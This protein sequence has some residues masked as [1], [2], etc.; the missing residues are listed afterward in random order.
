MRLSYVLSVLL[1]TPL[2]LAAQTAEELRVI[3]SMDGRMRNVT[4]GL[5]LSF[6]LGKRSIRDRDLEVISQVKNVC[7]LNLK[8]T[9]I[10]DAGLVHIGRMLTLRR[11]H[12]ELTNVTDLGIAHLANLQELE[13]LNLYG[14]AIT[15]DGISSLG[16]LK[17]LSRLYLWQTKITADGI[18]RLQEILPETKVITGIDLESIALPDPD[19]PLTPP[20][21]TL[22]FVATTIVSNAPKS[23]NGENIEV[24]FE[25]H[26]K[27]KV[28][29]VWVGYD[30]TLKV[31]AELAAGSSRVQNS[32]ENNTWLILDMKD[33]PLGYF[34]CGDER[35]LA[36][37]PE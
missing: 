1:L 25:N 19:A 33:K 32:Y 11:L 36:V 24:V 31:Y 21:S 12:L 22:K 17:S 20:S 14:T 7:V 35:A 13:Y 18:N 23:G 6:N 28:K 9:N 37:I 5:E 27:K 4:G 26:S 16:R 15:D 29:L 8:R 10:S 30:G 2:M 34:I 3:E